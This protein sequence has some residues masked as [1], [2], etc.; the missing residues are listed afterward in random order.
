MS[1][2]MEPL[3]HNSAVAAL[4][5]TGDVEEAQMILGHKDRLRCGG[6]VR[7]GVKVPKSSCTDAEKK[8]FV[9]LEAQGF[10]YDT[11]DEKL[12][13]Q[14]RSG[15]SKLVPRNANFFV[16]RDVDF[17]RPPDAQFIREKYADQ[18]GKVRTIPVWLSVGE[19]DRVLHHGFRA[20]NGAGSLVATSFYDGKKLMVRYLPK[21]FKGNPKRE[22]W[23]VAAFDPDKGPRD[24]KGKPL[25]PAGHAMDFGGIFRFNV[26]GLRGFDEIVCVTRSWYGMSYSVALLRRVRS[27]LGRFDGLLNGESFLQ[28]SKVAEEVTTPEGKKQ[29]QYIPVLELAVD[30]MELARYAEPMAVAAR[31]A[32]ARRALVGAATHLDAIQGVDQIADGLVPDPSQTPPAAPSRAD[33]GQESADPADDDAPFGNED[34]ARVKAMEYLHGAAKFLGVS[35]DQFATWAILEISGGVQIE[36]LSLEDLR[37]L[38]GKVKEGMR[39]DKNGLSEK[40]RSLAE[41]HGVN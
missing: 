21:D 23:L 8:L 38:A 41:A 36:D 11:I 26:P 7:T 19:I 3:D 4:I 29:T 17:S 18:D 28:L 16:V 20:F 25:S 27:I 12:G 10:G 35:W 13:G 22:D 30:P 32:K 9:E 34:P 5:E 31:A 2:V 33:A 40:V 1:E 39:A 37:D 6:V 24:A 15:K 14:P